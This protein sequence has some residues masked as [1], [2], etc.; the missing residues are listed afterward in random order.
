MGRHPH[1]GYPIHLCWS[2]IEGA[3]ARAPR[4]ASAEVRFIKPALT[5]QQGQAET[6]TLMRG[7]EIAASSASHGLS[8]L[9]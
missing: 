6:T 9:F 7:A 5:A 3:G 4:R 1:R 2:L 8:R